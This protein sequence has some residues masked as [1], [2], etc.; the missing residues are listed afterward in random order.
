MQPSHQQHCDVESL[1]SYL[2][3]QMTPEENANLESHL[4]HCQ[5]CRE[6][7]E[8]LSAEPEVW[9][10]ALELL[11]HEGV[12]TAQSTGESSRSSSLTNGL[13]LI[14]ALMPTDDPEMLGRLG[15]YE[16]S[17]I[18][19]IG[20][21]GA[22]LR[23]FDKSLRRVVAIKVMAPHLAGSGPARTRFQREARA[24]AAITHDNVIDI[25]GVSESNGIPYLVMPYARGPSLQKR[26][27][28]SGPLMPVEVVRIGWQ[29]AS[30]LAAAH[31]QGLVHRD[32]KPANILLN[33]GIERLWITDFGVARAIDDASMTQTGLIAG[34][35]Q[36]MS[37]EQARGET[38]DYRS[39]LFSLGSILY[40]ACTG[41]PPFRSEAAYG[42]LRRIT[43]SD[44]RPIREIN[45][46]IPVWLCHVVDRLMAKHPDDRF[47]HAQEVAECL[48]ACLAHLQQPTQVDLPSSIANPAE[49]PIRRDL[50][51]AAAQTKPPSNPRSF[52]IR[53]LGV[54]AVTSILLFAASGLFAFQ[55]TNPASIEGTW[56]GE[57]WSQVQL[58]TS[59]EAPGWYT[60]EFTDASGSRGVLH[61][62][63]SRTQRRFQGRWQIGAN[64]AGPITVRAAANGQLRGAITFDPQASVAQQ[65]LRLRD[66]TWQRGDRRPQDDSVNDMR[67]NTVASSIPIRGQIDGTVTGI[68]DQMEEQSFVPRGQVVAMI[69]RN[70]ASAEREARSRLESAKQQLRDAERLLEA[71]LDELQVAERS[72]Q[73][74]RDRVDDYVEARN[75]TKANALVEVRKAENSLEVMQQK[76]KAFEASIDVL[77]KEL[78]TKEIL[79]AEAAI[80]ETEIVDAKARLAAEQAKADENLIRVRGAELAIV[81][82]KG[83]MESK[84]R[85]AQTAISDA[86]VD[87][88]AADAELARVRT[89]VVQNRSEVT[90]AQRALLDAESELHELREQVPVFAPFD[91]K[92]QSLNVHK[93]MA[94]QKGDIIFH[95]IPTKPQPIP[96]KSPTSNPPTKAPNEAS[97]E[98][99][100]S[101]KDAI[102][103]DD[104][105]ENE[106][107]GE[108]QSAIVPNGE[109]SHTTY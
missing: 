102:E 90:T 26:I 94:V 11:A 87:A 17:G 89:M 81:T 74:A 91:G 85:Q 14:D 29:I 86:G 59:K 108:N 93:G 22:V 53:S 4:S 60:G 72:V 67:R 109:N 3:G 55:L 6:S 18:V 37:P 28:Q 16:I 36:Y 97:G 2:R 68:D 96:A 52:S 88:N 23:G 19:G 31:E 106:G 38:V 78:A 56:T 40:T 51:S 69:S 71:R 21:M 76:S 46:E 30:G 104:A 27:D 107:G 41:R 9:S 103:G 47:E 92:L 35:P 12:A 65:T 75:Q 7:I 105:F 98:Q 8:S 48:E 54:F 58:Q 10:N 20:G 64:Q 73:T 70:S 79:R 61:L 49:R 62:E 39:D 101:G 45:P 24:A 99:T 57:Q 63:W 95:L 77:K 13:H 1:E 66:F 15:D 42:V 43:D 82:T 25:Y 44:P 5:R 34:T 84:L 33:E 80:P 100:N 32:I 50:Q 83:E